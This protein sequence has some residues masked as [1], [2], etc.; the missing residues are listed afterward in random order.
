MPELF[1]VVPEKQHN[2]L[3][4]AAYQHRGFH[5]DESGEGARFCAE[6]E[7]STLSL[8]AFRATTL[9]IFR[10]RPPRKQRGSGNIRKQVVLYNDWLVK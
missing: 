7:A 8:P 5:A 1:Y 3:V 4:A 9:N 10:K 6:A 2:D